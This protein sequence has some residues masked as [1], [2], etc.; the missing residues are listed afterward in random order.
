MACR[1]R[2]YTVC[3]LLLLLWSWD[4]WQVALPP[5]LAQHGPSWW[6]MG[7]LDPRQTE[8]TVTVRSAV[9]EVTRPPSFSCP[10]C[11]LWP[12]ASHAPVCSWEA[13]SC[14]SPHGLPFGASHG[15]H[16][17]ICSAAGCG[18]RGPEGP[19]C[20]TSSVTFGRHPSLSVPGVLIYRTGSQ[21][22]LSQRCF[23]D[24]VYKA[25]KTMCST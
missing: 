11:G 14:R 19:S 1:G 12:W 10:F 18:S 21:W 8:A 24:Y 23:E 7:S 16:R 9:L 6:D 13:A 25:L 2:V 17:G 20:L 22:F 5:F 15:T 4:V 3:C